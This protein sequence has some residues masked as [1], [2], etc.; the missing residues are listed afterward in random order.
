MDLKQCKILVTPTSY[1][2]NDSRLKTELEN[3]VG[4]VM[5]NPT[6][7][8]LTSA[9]VAA[10]LPGVD[11][12]IAGL[13]AIDRDALQAADRL[14]V[15]CR[16]GV[17]VDNVDIAA[18]KEKGIVVTNTPGANSVSVAE[19]ALGLILALAR[20]IPE[21]VEA[22]HQ[23][24]WPRLSG[25]SLEGKT[26]GILGLG[27]IGK[28]LAK[29]LSGF[30]C[31]ILAYD[32]FADAVFAAENRIELVALDDVIAQA[33]FVSLHLPLLP[34]TRGM[35]NREFLGKMKKGSFLVNTSRGEAIDE[36]ALLEALKSGHLRG[37]GLDAFIKEPPEAD[38]PLLALPQVIATPH[39]GAQTDGATSNMGWFA[40]KDCLA[41]LKGEKP[42]Y[43][44]D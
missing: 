26:I 9:E 33:D 34:E 24:K 1:G 5:Y 13:D 6:G 20:Q 2:K 15:I 35:V 25:V 4:E 37:A 32:P 22:V 42:L 29:R 21:A 3:L 14:K 7:K 43:R 41:V 17:G 27:A 11:G 31:R 44:V 36:S 30:D 39:L 28:Q 10:L 19:L 8:P 18:A 40:L 23:G 12:Y 16:Y 38:H